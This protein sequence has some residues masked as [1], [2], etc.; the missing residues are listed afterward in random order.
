MQRT[1]RTASQA[2]LKSE[3]PDVETTSGFHAVRF[4]GGSATSA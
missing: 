1:H 4:A 2:R 3:K